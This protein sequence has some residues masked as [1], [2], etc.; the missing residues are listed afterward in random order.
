MKRFGKFFM[1]LQ[2]VFLTCGC[3][4]VQLRLHTNQQLRTSSDIIQQQVLDN[5][6]KIATNPSA[7]PEFSVLPTGL[8]Q[9]ADLGEGTLGLQWN[10]R[11]ITQEALGMKANRQL[12][13]KWDTK[14]V[15]DP[16]RLRAMW[17][18]YHYTTYGALP[19]PMYGYNPDEQLKAILGDQWQQIIPAPGWFCVTTKHETECLEKARCGC[20]VGRYCDTRVCVMSGRQAELQ[21]LTHI[22]MHISGATYWAKNNLASFPTGIRDLDPEEREAKKGMRSTPNVLR[23]GPP[24]EF[25]PV[26]SSPALSPIQ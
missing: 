12:T 5:L 15:I 1:A 11:T 17:A 24:I 20:L 26:P 22:I 18:V 4:H 23:L 16:A 21:Q 10:A 14:Q 2:F 25:E 3:T 7:W 8:T 9:M 13:E 19:P 6:A